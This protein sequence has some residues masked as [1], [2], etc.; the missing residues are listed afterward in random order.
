MVDKALSREER[1]KAL[2]EAFIS[3]MWMV[4]QQISQRLQRF[5]LTHPQFIVLASLTGHQQPCTMSDLTNV[6]F[7][8]PPTMTGI[9]DRLV[10]MKLVQRTRSD[11]DRRVVLAEV[12]PKGM[13]LVR[14]IEEE[15]LNDAK[16][17][18]AAFSDED[19][20][21]LEDL[22][23]YILRMHLSRYKPLQDADLDAEIEK[24][25]I[26]KNDPIRYAK[27]ESET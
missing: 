14:S 17:G 13:A 23:R 11:T 8:D 21:A 15:R 5:G 25:R 19:L 4:K 16:S 3:L 24:L 12:T 20:T 1:I 18:Y 26:F 2:D 10:K 6:T 27:L 7:Q 22:L 9:I